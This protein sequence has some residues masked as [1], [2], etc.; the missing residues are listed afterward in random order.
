[1]GQA[2]GPFWQLYT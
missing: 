2:G 1:M